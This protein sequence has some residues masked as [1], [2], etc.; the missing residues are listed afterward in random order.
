MAH[1]RVSAPSKIMR[2]STYRS[3]LDGCWSTSRIRKMSM[4][5]EGV[6]GE[7]PGG[8][9]PRGVRKVSMCIGKIQSPSK[10][11]TEL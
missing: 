9:E 1:L 8:P 6:G 3:A 5:S 2:A 4:Q 7:K 10:L 11:R